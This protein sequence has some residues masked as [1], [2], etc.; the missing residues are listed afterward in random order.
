MTDGIVWW[1]VTP[2]MYEEQNGNEYNVL[3]RVW[4]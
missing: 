1:K 4:T 3:E 2:D